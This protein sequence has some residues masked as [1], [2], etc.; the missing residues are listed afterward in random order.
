[1]LSC[2]P[3]EAATVILLRDAAP[4]ET[5]MVA[6]NPAARLMG[7]V[8]VFPGGGVEARDGSG[9]ERLRAAAIRELAEEVAITGLDPADLVP[10]SRWIAPISLAVRFDTHF[11]LARAPAGQEPAV[12]GVECVDAGWFSPAQVLAA[13]RAGNFPLL[14]PTRKS[15]ERLHSF[16]SIDDLLADA[17]AGA[18]AGAPIDPIRPRLRS[19]GDAADALLPGEPGYEAATG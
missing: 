2:E 13:E 4:F 3:R 19:P 11:F 8:W 5:L 1:V 15:L 14:L 16:N 7:G 17:D 18:G 9:E 6:R 10:F 12:D